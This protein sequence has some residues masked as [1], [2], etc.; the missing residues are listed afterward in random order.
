MVVGRKSGLR[1]NVFVGDAVARERRA[2]I[3]AVF[4]IT[5]AR[6]K[7]RCKPYAGRGHGGVRRVADGAHLDD[8]FVRDLVSE[9]HAKLARAM[10]HQF[11][12]VF[13]LDKSVGC[14]VADGDEVV[15]HSNYCIT[16]CF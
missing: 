1:L 3:S 13:K 10:V 4:I 12:G 9:T 16:Y 7:G 6:Y 8:L 2:A 5:H 15:F 11:F 14:N